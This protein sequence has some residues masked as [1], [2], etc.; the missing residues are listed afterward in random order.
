MPASAYQPYGTA[1]LFSTN[2]PP[3]FKSLTV[4]DQDGHK[5]CIHWDKPVSFPQGSSTLGSGVFA[6]AMASC[7]VF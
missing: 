1:S 5:S 2:I 3:G 4:A 6:Q 7:L